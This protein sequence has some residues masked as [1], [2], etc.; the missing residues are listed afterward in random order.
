MRRSY[1][2]PGGIVVEDGPDECALDNDR[3]QR[4]GDEMKSIGAQ[5]KTIAGL[6]WTADVDR[7]TSE[8]IDRMVEVTQNGR[9]TTMLTEAQVDWVGDIHKRHFG[10]K[11]EF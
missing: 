3:S 5:I 9:S 1:S 4:E 6:A 11:H 2:V 7:R 10:N 8:F